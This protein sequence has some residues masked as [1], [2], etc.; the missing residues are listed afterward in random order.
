MP[1]FALRAAEVD[2]RVFVVES[3]EHELVRAPVGVDDVE[4]RR[5]VE[6][7]QLRQRAALRQAFEPGLQRLA[8]GIDARPR[9]SACPTARTAC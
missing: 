9:R 7:P 8:A 3:G 2:L 6:Q 1:I 5:P 4:H